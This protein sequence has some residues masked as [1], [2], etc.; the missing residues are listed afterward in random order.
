MPIRLLQLAISLVVFCFDK[1]RDFLRALG[2]SP[3]PGK[4]VLINYH[5]ILPETRERFSRQIHLLTKI[6]QPL[7]K[8]AVRKLEAGVRYALVTFDDA[9]RSFAENALPVLREHNLP[10]LVFVP[11]GY[12]GRPSAWYDYGGLNPVGEEVL[13]PQEIGEIS[14]MPGVTIGSHSVTHPKM[15]EINSEELHRELKESKQSLES[16]LHSEID[17]ISFPYG[18]HG[19]RELEAAREHGYN[20]SLGVLP[21]LLVAEIRPG[22]IGRVSVHPSDWLIEFRLKVHGAYRW[23]LWASH[24]KRRLKQMLGASRSKGVR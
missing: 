13:S 20:F 17:S 18:S 5:S 12:M 7:P 19:P 22:L 21:E 9:F 23:M 24:C 10:V 1:F 8:L 15:A 11:T 3:R 16:L 2:G 6:A 4:C 14:Q